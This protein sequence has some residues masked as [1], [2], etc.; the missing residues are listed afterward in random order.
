M[1][2]VNRGPILDAIAPVELAGPVSSFL[3]RSRSPA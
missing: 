2:I 1:E 3:I